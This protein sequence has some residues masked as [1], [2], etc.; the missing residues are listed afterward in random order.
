MDNTRKNS[1]IERVYEGMRVVDSTG[2]DVGRVEMVKM[3]DPE[4]MTARGNRIGPAE[5]ITPLDSDYNEPEVPQPIRDD[6]LRVGFIKVDGANLFDTD[7]YLRADV[8]EAVEGDTVRIRLPKDRL[9]VEGEERTV[10]T[11]PHDRQ[12]EGGAIVMP[13]A[14]AGR[15]FPGGT[16]TSNQ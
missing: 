1:L 8:I 2:N 16:G 9:P 14:A 7:R 13:P 12:R 15:L 10:D 6:L 5:G 11:V 4:A 3:G